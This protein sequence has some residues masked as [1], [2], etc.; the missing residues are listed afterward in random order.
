MQ[1]RSKNHKTFQ[2]HV[3][4][5]IYLSFK[6]CFCKFSFL[7]NFAS[8]YIF[9]WFPKR[10]FILCTCFWICVRRMVISLLLRRIYAKFFL[11]PKFFLLIWFLLFEYNNFK[12][13]FIQY[14]FHPELARMRIMFLSFFCWR[15]NGLAIVEKLEEEALSQELFFRWKLSSILPSKSRKTAWT[16]ISKC[17][18]DGRRRWCL[19]VW[20]F[21]ASLPVEVQEV[22]ERKLFARSWV[23]VAIKMRGAN[24]LAQPQ[25]FRVRFFTFSTWNGSCAVIRFIVC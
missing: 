10:H 6:I 9:N 3:R 20:Y 1:K 25:E 13:K 16:F 2:T 22:Q 17:C 19:H 24:I 14:W 15:R 7:S 12:C 21:I 4:D 8:F 11:L 18:I 23:P 5:I